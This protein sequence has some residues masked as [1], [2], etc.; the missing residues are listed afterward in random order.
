MILQVLA[1]VRAFVADL[2]A[3]GLKHVAAA[4]AGELKDLRRAD[5]AGGKHGLAGCAG[6]FDRAIMLELDTGDAVAFDDQLAHMRL[7]QNRQ[8]AALLRRAQERL[9]RVPADAGAL[10]DVEI[11]GA[12]VAAAVEIRRF[13]NAGFGGGFLERVEHVPAHAGP[14]HPPFAASAVHVVGT[15]IVV[16][17]LLEERQHVVPA[18]AGA[19]EL[20]PMVVVARLAAH[21]DHA[22]DRGAAAKHLAAGIAE[23]TA[24]EALF[25]GRRKAPVGAR[26]VDAVEIADRNVDPVVVVAAAG[27]EQQHAMA[28]VFGKAIGKHA[29]GATRP[30]DDIVERVHW[31]LLVF[32]NRRETG[33]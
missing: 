32:G 14:F 17:R 8:V 3:V 20:A 19:A 25:G 5:R 26:I 13:G 12:F 10:V 15:L 7:G 29:A 1:D 33:A 6:A 9:R 11:A 24:V 23:G 28:Q 30:D 16:L 31:V 27:L 22:V 21:V 4:D 2:D 18:P